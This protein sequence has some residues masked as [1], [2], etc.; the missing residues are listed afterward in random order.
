M[1]GIGRRT[2]NGG[3]VVLVVV[4]VVVVEVVVVPPLGVLDGISRIAA[5]VDLVAVEEAVLVPVDADP[6]ARPRRDAMVG[7][8]LPCHGGV[9]AQLGVGERGLAPAVALEAAPAGPEPPALHAGEDALHRQLAR[10]GR[11]LRDHEVDPWAGGRGVR[12]GERHLL[13]DDR[14]QVRVEREHEL[15]EVRRLRRAD[16]ERVG[17]VEA[18]ERVDAAVVQEAESAHLLA[19]VGRCRRA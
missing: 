19:L 9:G 4:D 10:A 16:G 14:L 5:G 11:R 1:V 6:H 18:K 12:A 13:A 17:A 2:W 8:L 3:L 7:A 15:L